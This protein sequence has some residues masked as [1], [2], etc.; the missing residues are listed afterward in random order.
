MTPFAA[1]TTLIAA[2]LALTLAPNAASACGGCF[3][4]VGSPTV[5]TRHQMA[6]SISATETTLWDQIEY[7]GNPEDFVWVLPVRGG[8]PVELADNAFFEA[9]EQATTIQLQAPTPPVTFCSDPCGGF[10]AGA[11]SDRSEGFA[12]AGSTVTVHHQ[13]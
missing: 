8:V 1:R 11:A 13:A 6:V 9:L 5:V 4:P 3:A 7:A 12:D 2:A 10:L